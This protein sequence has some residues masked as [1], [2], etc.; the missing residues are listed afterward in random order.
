[1][2]RPNTISRC[3]PLSIGALSTKTGVNIET[4]RYYEKIGLLPAPYRSEGRQRRYDHGLM[5]RLQF[6]RRARE[7][8]FSI[9]E[10][11]V[12]LRLA[13]HGAPACSEAKAITERHLADIRGK[14][15]DL[16]KLSRVLSNLTENCEA[17][18][19]ALCP[20]LE[21]LG[22]RAKSNP[23]RDSAVPLVQ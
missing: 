23:R 13:D 11:R 4:I 8:G 21:T 15:A 22:G 7:L 3:E 16:K 19:Q 17:D 20:I 12:L 1:M 10:I 14:I 18:A 9:D 5:Q 6:V 2:L